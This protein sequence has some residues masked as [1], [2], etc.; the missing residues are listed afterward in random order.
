MH[1]KLIQVFEYDHLK[2]DDFGFTLKHFDALTAFSER[3]KT[4]WFR[5]GYRCIHFSH[6]VGVIQVDG[7]TIEIL[8]KID[9]GENKGECQKH[10][11]EMLCQTGKLKLSAP[12]NALLQWKK[13]SI[14]DLYIGYFVKELQTLIHRGL[15]R[16]YRR[17]Q[18]NQKALKGKLLVGKQIRE[19]LIHKERFY[20]EY[21][22]YDED[23]ILHQI[24]NEALKML[25]DYSG[26]RPWMSE[27][28]S[29][30]MNFPDCKCININETIFFKINWDRKNKA[31]SEAIQIA[32]ML[33]LNFH[34]DL[35][36]GANDVL[37]LLFNMNDL[38]ESW[39]LSSLKK[40]AYSIPEVSVSG[41]QNKR[42]WTNEEDR[43]VNIRPDILLFYKGEPIMVLDTKWKRMSEYDK[44]SANDL[45]QL[46]A[47]NHLFD[48]EQSYLLYPGHSQLE[49]NNGQFGVDAKNRCGV[50]M[51]PIIRDANLNKQIG[52]ELLDE[53]MKKHHISQWVR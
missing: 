33:L 31:Y 51:L 39:V 40:A 12:S 38:F 5:L 25:T 36:S 41:Q 32:Q 21:T 10:L 46:F 28:R 37:A 9:K 23:H 30:L 42:F 3:Q 47:Y 49:V 2:I 16:R 13:R 35:S 11:I 14:L 4:P 52:Q 34:P 27:I 22:I 20:C 45:Q 15:I 7:L 53:F 24:L 26:A 48:V 17:E 1:N 18:G 44:P 50:C 19:N 43:Y 29:L 6:Y 8:P